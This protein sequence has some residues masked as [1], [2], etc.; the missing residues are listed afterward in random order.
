MFFRI[1]N[2]SCQGDYKK[3]YIVTS[4][5]WIIRSLK[6]LYDQAI[7]SI[8]RRGSKNSKCYLYLFVFKAF[9]LEPLIP[10]LPR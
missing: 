10:C 5:V 8:W 3:W 7:N 9:S 2:L 1:F 4:K 6:I